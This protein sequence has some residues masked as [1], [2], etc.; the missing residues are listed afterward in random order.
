MNEQ[1][2][3]N[4]DLVNNL[5]AE[6]AVKQATAIQQGNK[7]AINVGI[8]YEAD[9][10]VTYSGTLFFRRPSSMDYIRMGAIKSELLRTFGIRPIVEYVPTPQGGFD[11]VESMAHVDNSVKY[12]AQ[13]IAACDVLITGQVPAWF[14]NHRELEDTDL[15]VYVYRRFDEELT[16]FRSGAKRGTSSNSEIGNDA[17][18]VAHPQAIRERESQGNGG[19]PSAE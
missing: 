14:Q 4:M 1:A 2:K 15:V 9:S 3:A 6:N 8:E 11:R 10:G 17:E 13:A 12:L 5:M 16:S 7:A 19:N 18:N